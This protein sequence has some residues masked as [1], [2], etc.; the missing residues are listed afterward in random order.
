MAPQPE[1]REVLHETWRS[2]VEEALGR[3]SSVEK[4]EVTFDAALLRSDR[5]TLKPAVTDGPPVMQR[6]QP[7]I[8]D[9]E[10][11]FEVAIP[12]RLHPELLD[13]ETHASERFRVETIYDYHGPC[14]FVTCLDGDGDRDGSLAVRLLWRF[15]RQQIPR[16]SDDIVFTL[17]GPSPFHAS[18]QLEPG[19]TKGQPVSWEVVRHVGYSDIRVHFSAEQFSD[20]HRAFT[21]VQFRLA[22]ELSLFYYLVRMQNWGREY[23]RHLTARTSA[24]VSD[25]NATG[26]RASMHR[27]FGSA[28]EAR[29]LGLDALG[30]KLLFAHNEE[31]ALDSVTRVYAQSDAVGCLRKW[32]DEVSPTT[33]SPEL[34]TTL[35]V[36]RFAEAGRSKELEIAIL[37][38]STLLGGIA[39]AAAAMIAG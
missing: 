4:V 6:F 25:H 39:G 2:K 14:T 28:A 19:D 30:A 5:W 17:L 26:W 16:V 1:E 31:Y 27:V 29:S 18:F 13:G 22:R 36:V 23:S 3:I 21:Y 32:V 34:E 11:T 9:A 8:P 10:V 15:L 38:A 20:A 37:S 35:E 12:R 33:A 7:N 24:L